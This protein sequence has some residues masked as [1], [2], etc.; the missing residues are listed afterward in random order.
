[1]YHSLP[2][3]KVYKCL[4]DS[5]TDNTATFKLYALIVKLQTLHYIP[6]LSHHVI[7]EER[8]CNRLLNTYKTS[9]I[10]S[11]VGIHPNTVRLY[12]DL[13]FIPKP[14]WKANGYRLFTEFHR[15]QLKLART[16]LR[17]EMVQSGLNHEITRT[18]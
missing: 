15:E 9:E 6:R 11:S 14:E 7:L 3:R 13:G 17:V 18:C 4:L 10:A 1:M 2:I 8:R 5:L 16:A 12:E